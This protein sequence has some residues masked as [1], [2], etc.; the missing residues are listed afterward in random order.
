MSNGTSDKTSVV[1]AIDGRC[2]SGKSTFAAQLAQR[3]HWNLIHMDDFFPRPEQRTS[4]RL[5]QPGGNVDYE[6]VRGEV[7]EPLRMGKTV[8]YQPFDCHSMLLQSPVTLPRRRVTLIEGSYACHPELWNFYDLRV[9][10]TVAPD[11]QAE[12]ILHRNGSAYAQIFR[13]RWIPMEED[14]FSAYGIEQRCDAVLER[15]F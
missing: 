9:F 12:R 7:L 8:C 11:V 6:R 1:I 14:Y 2:A 13:E 3:Y 10:L 15:V 5:S 4:A